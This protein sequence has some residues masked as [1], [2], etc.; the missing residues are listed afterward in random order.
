MAG[1]FVIAAGIFSL[2]GAIL[3]WDWYMNHRKARFLVRIFGRGGARVF[4]GVLGL[5]L[6]ILG[7]LLLFGF[8]E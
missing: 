2:C 7:G 6:I 5:G 1:L 3:N 4:Y 8:I